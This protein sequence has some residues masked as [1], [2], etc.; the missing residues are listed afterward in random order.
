MLPLLLTCQQIHTEA[1]NV[2]YS[3]NIFMFH[4]SSLA[5]VAL[6]VFDV[7]PRRY[8]KVMK[9]AYLRTEVFLPW[10]LE[11]L[12]SIQL[13]LDNVDETDRR[14]LMGKGEVLSHLESEGSKVIA[15]RALPPKS[16]FF[17]NCKDTVELPAAG[18]LWKTN[19]DPK[20]VYI[21]EWWSSSCH[22][23]KMVLL[24]EPEPNLRQEF[25]RIVWTTNINDTQNTE[26]ASD[27]EG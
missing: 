16:G 11:P 13:R 7:L 2:L 12:N 6:P 5:N 27:V 20:E 15:Q 1:S 24:E 9:R 8:L 26:E 14:K 18:W 17:V 21:D 3:E 22:L 10:P 4:A 25:R 19:R 23:W